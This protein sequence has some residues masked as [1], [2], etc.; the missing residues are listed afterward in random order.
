MD[1][2]GDHA[3]VCPCNGDRPTRHIAVRDI[4]ACE[5]RGAGLDPEP[6]KPGLL[7]GRPGED[8]APDAAPADRAGGHDD[9]RRPA[10][11]WFPRGCKE[12]ARSPEAMDFAVTS[13]LQTKYL[14]AAR[15]DPNEVFQAYE[16]FMSQYKDTGQKCR[17]QG[18]TFTPAILEAHGGGWSP[19][20]RR[21]VAYVAGRRQASDGLTEGVSHSL[22]IA[23][24][25]SN[26][27]HQ[28]NARAILKRMAA[29]QSE[30]PLHSLPS[31]PEDAEDSD[32]WGWCQAFD[33]PPRTPVAS[34]GA[35]DA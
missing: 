35:D 6:E 8:G 15:R 4:L 3:L 5:S 28:G 13:G 27:L 30:L 20:L 18:L 19:A 29:P 25:I 11:I 1:V 17:Q 31:M 7:P 33:T 10:D 9:R 2:F 16:D 21:A 22:R 34:E 12:G 23:Q 32:E 26:A 24:R 14:D